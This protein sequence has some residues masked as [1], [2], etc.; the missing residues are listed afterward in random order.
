M[1]DQELTQDFLNNNDAV[2]DNIYR[3]NVQQL[4]SYGLRLG[5]ESEELKDYIQDIFYKLLC[6]SNFLNNV[7]NVRAYL[8][9]ALKN[10]WQ[11]ALRDSKPT[12]ELDG[13]IHDFSG[14]VNA[15]ETIIDEEERASMTSR[16]N[17]LLASLTSRQREAVF[18]RY[19]YELPYEEIAQMLDMSV[20][21]A[22]NLISRAIDHMRNVDAEVL[23]LFFSI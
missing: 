14:E 23:L 20:P 4:Y 15:L 7:S 1:N 10:R 18:L 13:A 19:I 22:R 6:N 2:Y 11:N 21:S 3:T 16:L 5:L 8:F 9:R 12:A 17:L